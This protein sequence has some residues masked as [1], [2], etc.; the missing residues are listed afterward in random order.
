[1]NKFGTRC[2]LCGRYSLSWKEKKD[3]TIVCDI[4]YDKM[5]NEKR[6]AIRRFF[7]MINA[8]DEISK[9]ELKKIK[10]DIVR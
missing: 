7:K 8:K 10:K 1:M 6:D 4:C 2:H 3:G 5:I 9:K